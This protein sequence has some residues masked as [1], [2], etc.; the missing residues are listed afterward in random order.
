MLA[1]L[2]AVI[3]V[4]FIKRPLRIL[5]YMGMCC[6]CDLQRAGVVP[7]FGMALPVGGDLVDEVGRRLGNV[8][9]DDRQAELARPQRAFWITTNAEPDWQLTGRPRRNL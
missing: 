1:K 6:Y 3:G 2:S 4:E 9:K 5:R 8:C 7:S